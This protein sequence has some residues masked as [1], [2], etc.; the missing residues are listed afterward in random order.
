MIPKV[1]ILKSLS[2]LGLRFRPRLVP[3]SEIILEKMA[4]LCLQSLTL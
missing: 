1:V 3:A 2:N 4:K